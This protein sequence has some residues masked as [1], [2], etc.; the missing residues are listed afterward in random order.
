MVSH[1]ELSNL[2]NP[3]ASAGSSESSMASPVHSSSSS[4][5]NEP[6]PQPALATAVQTINIRSH[7]P[8]LLD[9]AQWNYS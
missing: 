1:T 9:L 2:D 7:V 4:D 3:F 8:V 6:E 5:A